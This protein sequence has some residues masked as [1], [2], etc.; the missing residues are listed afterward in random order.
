[1]FAGLSIA[2]EARYI[3]ET[4]SENISSK[5]LQHISW[6]FDDFLSFS[7]KEFNPLPGSLFLGSFGLFTEKITQRLKSFSQEYPFG[8]PSNIMNYYYFAWRLKWQRSIGNHVN[9]IFKSS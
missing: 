3:E 5:I 1:M 7:P 4:P 9:V 6:C 8:V 2:L